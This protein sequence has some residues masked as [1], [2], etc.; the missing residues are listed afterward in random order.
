MAVAAKPIVSP[1]V[2]ASRLGALW[3]NAVGKKAL[4]AVTGIVLF[5]YVVA[6]LA[7]NLQVFLGPERL[8]RYGELLRVAPSLL[9]TARI[10]LLAAAGVHV[11]AGIQLW[12]ERRR[13]RPVAYRTWRPVASTPASRTMIWSGLL[14]LGFVVY[15]LLD[16]TFG[17]ANPDFRGGDIYHNLVESLARAAAAGFYLV[18]MVGLGFHLWHG[19][20]S[21]FQSLGLANRAVSETIQRFA[22]SVAVV[23]TLGFAA[24]P[25]AVL[26]GVVG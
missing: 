12:L 1:S 11:V 24:I 17:L 21:M 23:L 19:L 15:H 3:R 4:M 13:A 9:W 10:V 8:N 14:L 22:V 25:L 2:R 5:A 26:L 6:H 16:L 18:A 7:G 20:W